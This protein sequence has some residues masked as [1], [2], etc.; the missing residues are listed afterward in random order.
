MHRTSSCKENSSEVHVSE[1]EFESEENQEILNEDQVHHENVEGLDQTEEFLP[2]HDQSDDFFQV[3]ESE[4]GWDYYEDTEAWAPRRLDSMGS[5]LA[6]TGR[7]G[8]DI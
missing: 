8:A 6:N 7:H 1:L 4:D 5:L 3:H 2:V